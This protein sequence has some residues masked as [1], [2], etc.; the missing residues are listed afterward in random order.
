[1]FAH[2]VYSI[3]LIDRTLSGTTTQ[4]QSGP[5]NNVNDEV[6]HI[7]QISKARTLPSD[8]LMSYLGHSLGGVLPLYRD[9]V[10]VFYSPNR[11]G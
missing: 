11:L 7:P 5:G 3:G 6:F 10:G 2:T 8:G 1:M 4:G 9:A